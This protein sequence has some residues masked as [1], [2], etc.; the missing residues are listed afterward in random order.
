VAA[1][2]RTWWSNV[3]APPDT[4]DLAVHT[5]RKGGRIVLVGIHPERVLLSTLEI[6]LGEKRL[7][8]SVQHHYDEDLPHRVKRTTR[9]KSSSGPSAS[10]GRS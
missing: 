6:I 10:G 2:A 1:S 4:A 7:V 8:G 3:P 9:C 5:A